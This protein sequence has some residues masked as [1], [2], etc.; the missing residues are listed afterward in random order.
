MY[1]FSTT[2]TLHCPMFCAFKATAPTR[3]WMPRREYLRRSCYQEAAPAPERTPDK[4]APSSS[5]CSSHDRLPKPLSSSISTCFQFRSF[6]TSSCAEAIPNLF[7]VSIPC[8]RPMQ[9]FRHQ[10]SRLHDGGACAPPNTLSHDQGPRV[11][12]EPRIVFRYRPTG[13]HEGCPGRLRRTTQPNQFSS[14]SQTAKSCQHIL[15]FTW[16]PSQH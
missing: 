16:R 13:V 8:L 12:S 9:F 11:T 7:I 5:T 6:T 4:V 2:N 1:K 15:T 10:T 3:A 14:K